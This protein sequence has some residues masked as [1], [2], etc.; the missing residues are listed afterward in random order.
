MNNNDNIDMTNIK[1]LSY[2]G[3]P[4]KIKSLKISG[5]GG[6]TELEL[7]F[8]E[9]FNVI[10]GANGIGKTTI[11]NIISDAFSSNTPSVLKR[12]ALYEIGKYT[13]EINKQKNDTVE[14]IDVK[15]QTIKDF[16]P[17]TDTYPGG[18]QNYAR[19]IL[20]FKP[21]RDITYIN[22]DSISSDPEREDFRNG[23]LSSSGVSALDIKN[24]FVNRYLFVD[25]S[26][27]LSVA[28]IENHHIAETVFGILDST[29]TFST[30]L[31][32]SYDIIL[33][34]AKGDIYFEYLSSGYKTCIYIILG[35][36]KEIEYRFSEPAINVHDFD[37]VILIDEIDLHLHPTWQAALVKS[38]KTVFPCA[39]FIVTTHSPSVL[40]SLE[41]DEIIPLGIDENNNTFIKELN[42]GEYGLQGWT[43]EEILKDVM[44]MPSTTSELFKKTLHQY[45]KAMDNEDIPEIKRTYEMLDKMLH[46]TSTLRKLLQIQMVGMEE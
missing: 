27:S 38:L 40:Q 3:K 8:N 2:E 33:S 17:I 9:Q 28:E 44:G 30:V 35:I 24:W 16:K 45:D 10:C 43:L 4:M 6:I 23:T 5:V 46:P 32:R 19:S 15:E 14:D 39:Q 26:G 31:A 21:S 7:E 36:I 13:I 12:N 22:L 18:W 42:L 11:L 37:G 20:T 25:K 41:K 1:L 29:V 34:T